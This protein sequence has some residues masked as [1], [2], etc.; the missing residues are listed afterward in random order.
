MSLT[1]RTGKCILCDG[2]LKEQIEVRYDPSTGPL[3][4]GPGSRRQYK[5]VS[6]GFVCDNCGLRY[7]TLPTERETQLA[8]RNDLLLQLSKATDDINQLNQTIDDMRNAITN[9]LQAFGGCGD[10]SC[11]MQ[12]PKGMSTN[13]GC[14]CFADLQT[15]DRQ[16]THRLIRS[17]KQLLTQKV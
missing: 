5:E 10:N 8:S 17:I 16:R 6:E 3:I 14:R 13:G 2:T 15:E 4:M 12:K 9:A 1:P 7:A 11:M